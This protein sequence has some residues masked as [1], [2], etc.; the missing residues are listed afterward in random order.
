MRFLFCDVMPTAFHERRG[1]RLGFAPLD[2]ALQLTG[3][4]QG[5]LHEFG[6]A[7]QSDEIK[8]RGEIELGAEFRATR[9]CAFE[10]VRELS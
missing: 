5:L 7:R 3:N 10:E 4:F 8:L 1:I 6:R 2:E 9:A